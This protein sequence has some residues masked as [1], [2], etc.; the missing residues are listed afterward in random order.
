MR[1]Q[2]MIFGLAAL[3][4]ACGSPQAPESANAPDPVVVEEA[5]EAADG[6]AEMAVDAAAEAADAAE[7]AGEAAADAADAAA[8]AVDAAEDADDAAEAA[9]DDADG[10]D[11]MASESDAAPMG[12]TATDPS[13]VVLASGGP[14]F[15]KFYAEW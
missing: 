10:E 8:A 12:F 3:L 2:W 5:A 6:M 1:R 4:G 15:V 9:A 14:Q 11:G 13:T 7:A